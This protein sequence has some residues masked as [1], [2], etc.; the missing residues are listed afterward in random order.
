MELI[1]T[2][3][4]DH[5]IISFQPKRFGF[6]IRVFLSL[7]VSIIFTTL[8][9]YFF[10]L[11]IQSLPYFTDL[12]QPVRGFA[13]TIVF[14]VPLLITSSS[15]FFVFLI[16]IDNL[17]LNTLD[18]I[19]WFPDTKELMYED[20][21]HQIP[22][23]AKIILSRTEIIPTKKKKRAKPVYEY[24]LEIESKEDS[25]QIFKK[26]PIL[27]NYL[28]DKKTRQS[29]LQKLAETLAITFVD[30]TDDTLPLN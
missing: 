25:I 19:K 21:R 5:V 28:D 13:L 10:F 7:F 14:Y 18:A 16:P 15:G 8:W 9:A 22:P 30:K 11:A 3:K 23:D 17:L 20:L 1:T 27:T 29:T 4:E 2:E 26:S 6:L 12:D 24:T